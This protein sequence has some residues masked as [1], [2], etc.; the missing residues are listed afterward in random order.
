MAVSGHLWTI[1]PRLHGRLWPPPLPPWTE[2]ST[3]VPDARQGMV[4]LTGRLFEVQDATGLFVVIHGLGGSVR[5]PYLARAVWAAREAGLAC[6]LLNLRG[7][8]RLGEDFYH[9]GLIADL[10]APLACPQLAVYEDIYFFGY[11]LGGHVVLRWAVESHD[12]RVR[13]VATLAS[14][15]DLELSAE[16]YKQWYMAAY[17]RF[18]LIGLRNIYREVAARGP[19]PVPMEQAEQVRSL[20]DWDDLIV[21]PRHGFEGA[22][23]YYRQV[24]VAPHLERLRVPTLYVGSE[25]DPMVLA[26]TVKPYLE[27]GSRHLEVCWTD[28]GG[29]LGFPRHL[30]LGLGAAPGSA[31]AQVLHW[32]LRHRG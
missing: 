17:Q 3:V 9:A 10:D 12:P 22:E 14:P 21:A 19:V 31:E 27:R 29:H 1:L 20:W 11:S 24:S 26:E 16:T 30:D 8:D 13:A 28:R 25:A 7:A 15:V 5:S 2:W 23:D 18:L 32:L 6:L 4:R